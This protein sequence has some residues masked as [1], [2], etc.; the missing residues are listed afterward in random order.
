MSGFILFIKEFT[1]TCILFKHFEGSHRSLCIIC[2]FFYMGQVKLCMD[3]NHMVIYLTLGKYKLLLFPHPWF[4]VV[5][6]A[7]KLLYS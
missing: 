4:S 6:S 3:K 7:D 2:F 1:Y 5:V